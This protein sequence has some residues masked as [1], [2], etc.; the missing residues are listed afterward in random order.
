VPGSAAAMTSSRG[1]CFFVGEIYSRIIPQKN[2]A[3]PKMA[4]ITGDLITGLTRKLY[5][6]R[7]SHGETIGKS[8]YKDIPTKSWDKIR[9]GQKYKFPKLE[10]TPIEE[11]PTKYTSVQY[12]VEKS[13][14]KAVKKHMGNPSM[15]NY[16]VGLKT[17]RYY[18]KLEGVKK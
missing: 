12:E 17:F 14:I 13:L 16:K 7:D 9:M 2:N 11:Q 4:K 15:A 5:S 10:G 6:I 18:V 3:M 8:I 1:T